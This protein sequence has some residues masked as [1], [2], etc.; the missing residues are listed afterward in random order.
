MKTRGD[1]LTTWMTDLYVTWTVILVSLGWSFIL[2][3]IFLLFLVICDDVIVYLV[4]K[5]VFKALIVLSVIFKL[6]V[7]EIKD[8]VYENIMITFKLNNIIFYNKSLGVFDLN[9]KG[10]RFEKNY[11]KRFNEIFLINF[12]KIINAFI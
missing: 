5:L 1:R 11:M 10:F 12:I 4:I 8:E 9:Y 3:L 7:R 2:C 6:Y